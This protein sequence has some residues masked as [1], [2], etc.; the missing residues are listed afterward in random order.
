MKAKQSKEEKEFCHQGIFWYQHNF[1]PD[2]FNKDFETRAAEWYSKVSTSMQT[3]NYYQQH[4]QQECKEE[5]AR[6]YALLKGIL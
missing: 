6:R 3:D 2:P 4:T 5:W 1:P